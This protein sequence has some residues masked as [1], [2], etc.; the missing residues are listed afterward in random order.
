MAHLTRGIAT[1]LIRVLCR[2]IGIGEEIEHFFLFP[3]FPTQVSLA[4]NFMM[5]WI[6]SPIIFNDIM[7]RKDICYIKFC[8]KY[9]IFERLANK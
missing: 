6:V 5:R 4:F 8:R 1:F 9:R 3:F 7:Y 2:I